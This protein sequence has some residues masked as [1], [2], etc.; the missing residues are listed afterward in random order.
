MDLVMF[1]LGRYL[2]FNNPSIDS[3]VFHRIPSVQASWV[4]ILITKRS[5]CVGYYSGALKSQS[6]SL[7]ELSF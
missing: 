5:F 7:P 4:E 3:F 2:F 1:T 6:N